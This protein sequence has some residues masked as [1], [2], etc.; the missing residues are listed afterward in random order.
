M[1]ETGTGADHNTSEF[2]GQ[3]TT[4]VVPAACDVSGDPSWHTDFTW[5]MDGIAM[6]MVGKNAIY[7]T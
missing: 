2:A 1:D 5:W 6:L 7:F 4:V 3:K